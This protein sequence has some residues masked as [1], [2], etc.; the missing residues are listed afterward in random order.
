MRTFLFVALLIAAVVYIPPKAYPSEMI[1]ENYQ[2]NIQSSLKD[3]L[4]LFVP[5]SLSLDIVGFL[6]E[7][8]NDET[9]EKEKNQNPTS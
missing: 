5:K 7:C 4:K 2:L 3:S 1:G 8:F 9:V 6:K